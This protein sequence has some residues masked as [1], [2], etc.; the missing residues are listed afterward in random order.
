MAKFI[1][2][3]NTTKVELREMFNCT[4][5]MVWYALNYKKGSLLANRIRK[6]ALDKGGV[7][8]DES[9]QTFTNLSK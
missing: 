8:Y 5:E 1:A 3:P 4:K 6:V 7:I 2:V 9:K